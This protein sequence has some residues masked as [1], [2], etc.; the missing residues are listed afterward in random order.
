MAKHHLVKILLLDQKLKKLYFLLLIQILQQNQN[1]LK[2]LKKK[3]LKLNWVYYIMKQKKFIN[4]IYKIKV[5]K[6][7]LLQ[8]S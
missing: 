3:E 8:E 1:L 2:F 4:L 7:L 5:K 6:C